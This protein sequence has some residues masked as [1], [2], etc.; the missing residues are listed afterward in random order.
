MI[1]SDR[2]DI[3]VMRY[4]YKTREGGATVTV[5]VPYDCGNHC[6]FCINKG[7]YADTG[8]FDQDR[9]I[10][11]IKLMDE[12]TPRC[13]FVFTGGE[14]FSDRRALQSM[15][16]VLPDTHRIFINTTLPVFPGQ[17]EQDIKD[18]AEKNKAKIT[19]I[20]VSRHLLKYVTE[21]RDELLA[22]LAVPTRVNCVL[23][24]PY[25]AE[26]LPGYIERWLN[27]KVPVQFRYDYTATTPENLYRV[28]D[29]K[30][31]NDLSAIAGYTGLDGCRMRNGYHFDYKGLELTYHRTLPYSTIVEKDP[32]DGV[33]YAILYDI[34]IKQ[35]GDI[36]SDWDDRVMDYHLDI[37]AYRHVKFEPYDLKV[38]EGD[39]KIK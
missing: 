7:E 19:C 23:F 30:I 33:T 22:E 37:E 3:Q 1:Q 16:D 10:E 27:L 31:F 8:S 13:D 9:I 12:I 35:N 21:T 15:L 6:P 11:S 38:L 17:S 20:N 34:I 32:E 36:H 26:K 14:P 18:F 39:I 24:D 5:F 4:P 2:D 29:D 25:P 28:E